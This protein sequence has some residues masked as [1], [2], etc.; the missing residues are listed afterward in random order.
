[1]LLTRLREVRGDW[2]ICLGH[3]R[4]AIR[5]RAMQGMAEP[6]VLV[7][8]GSRRRVH[9]DLEPSGKVG[10]GEAVAIQET[11]LWMQAT[12]GVDGLKPELEGPLRRLC[13]RRGHSI[14]LTVVPCT[15]RLVGADDLRT[16]H[17]AMRTR[18]RALRQPSDIAQALQQACG[19]V[20]E[21]A[22]VLRPALLHAEVSAP[23]RIQR[24]VQAALDRLL[25]RGRRL[26]DACRAPRALRSE[27]VLLV[28]DG[29]G[30]RD[31]VARAL[32]ALLHREASHRA[33]R[34]RGWAPV[35]IAQPCD[36]R[37]VVPVA[38]VAEL[39]CERCIVPQLTRR[40]AT[41]CLLQGLRRVLGIRVVFKQC[42]DL[43]PRQSF[44][45]DLKVLDEA[46][47]PPLPW[48]T[49]RN[50]ELRSVESN[51]FRG[52]VGE[53]RINVRHRLAI[54]RRPT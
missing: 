51:I 42:L 44:V 50:P 21:L 3:L 12:R 2:H 32:P 30:H 34:L 52:L 36:P 4:V 27:L 46:G 16:R 40:L 1:M 11:Q 23:F 43:R 13:N 24:R 9:H 39:V 17:E 14:Q 49:L 8:T 47:V 35:A 15:C 54:S 7:A 28:P 48:R 53:P 26:G 41:L 25:L 6:C 19:V 22:A 37:L 31:I 20:L 18:R 10:E 33:S 38:I 29:C 5:L 45:I